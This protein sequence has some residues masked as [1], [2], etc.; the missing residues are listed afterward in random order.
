MAQT[1]AHL[2]AC[3]MPWVA[4]R[5]WVVSVPIPL[6][7]WM[8]SSRDLTAQVHRTIRNAIAQYYVNQAVSRGA[9]RHKVQPGSVTFIQRFGSAINANLHF[10]VIFLEG[11]Y[12]G[13]SEE[14]LTPRFVEA[15]PPSNADISDVLRK[16]SHRVIRKLR[17]LG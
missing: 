13:R 1:A 14:G 4:M 12:H 2:V 17:R 9:E 8:A 15:D 7:Y 11:V 10:H 16:I 5:Q 3:V 6:R